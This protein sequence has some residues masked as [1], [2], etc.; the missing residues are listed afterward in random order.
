MF[1]EI[2][3]FILVIIVLII[4]LLL[5]PFIFLADRGFLKA[6]FIFFTIIWFSYRIL[7][8]IGLSGDVSALIIGLSI[9][10]IVLYAFVHDPVKNDKDSENDLKDEE[11]VIDKATVNQQIDKPAEERES[12]KETEERESIFIMKTGNTSDI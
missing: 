1:Y 6:I 12:E 9:G 7:A 8:W 3:M 4:S 5:N 11:P 10:W 2:F